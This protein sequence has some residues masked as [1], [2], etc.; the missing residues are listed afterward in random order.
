[1]VKTIIGFFAWCS[2]LHMLNKLSQPQSLYSCDCNDT[3]A[4]A[5]AIRYRYPLSLSVK[6]WTETQFIH[7]NWAV[8]FV[9]TE[10]YWH[11][12]VDGFVVITENYWF[13]AHLRV[14]VLCHLLQ[15]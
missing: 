14:V 2:H 5:I 6:Y 15:R 13:L 4:I 12:D 1:M 10:H 11:T 7:R 8:I 9:T 3:R